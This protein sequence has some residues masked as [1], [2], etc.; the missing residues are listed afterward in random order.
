ML[1]RILPRHIE[2]LDWIAHVNW[3]FRDLKRR[4]PSPPSVTREVGKP[5]FRATSIRDVGTPLYQLFV[6]INS[7]PLLVYYSAFSLSHS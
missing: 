6:I 7:K 3:L 2:G 4:S 1:M 5:E